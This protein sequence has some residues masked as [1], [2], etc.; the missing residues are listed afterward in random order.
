VKVSKRIPQVQFNPDGL[1]SWLRA[2][3]SGVVIRYSMTG[4]KASSPDN[5]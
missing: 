1:C 5:E 3:A 4:V 2:P